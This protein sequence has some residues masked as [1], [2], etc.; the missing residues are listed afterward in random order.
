MNNEKKPRA[1]WLAAFRADSFSRATAALVG[2]TVVSQ[3]I[4]TASMLILTRLYSPDDFKIA[5]IYLSITAT[6]AAVACLRLE[7]AIPH[8]SSDL[9][10]AHLLALSLASSAVLGLISVIFIGL[11]SVLA[12]SIFD[13]LGGSKWLIPAGIWIASSFNALQY[14]STR[15]RRF[16]E[17]GRS[18]IIQ[19]CTSVAVQT[20]LGAT[21]GG[22][23]G[24]IVGHT[25][26]MGAGCLWL[27]RVIFESDRELLSQISLIGA[28]AQFRRYKRFPQFS[29]FEAFTNV[30]GIQ[31]PILAIAATVANAEAGFVFLAMRVMNAPLQI[32]GGAIG[33]VFLSSASEQLRAGCLRAYTYSTLKTL[34]KLGIIPL[35]FVGLIAPGAFSLLFGE[36]W[37]RTG[38]LVQWMTPWFILQF[39]ASPISMA[40]HVAGRVALALTIQAT[41]MALRLGAVFLSA[42]WLHGYVGE[43]YAIS[44]AVFYLLYLIVIMV[45]V[46][47]GEKSPK[48]S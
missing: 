14:W 9:D 16:T 39:L 37:R 20:T 27:L 21:A 25:V 5:S 8:P 22:P 48:L 2:S 15:S 4:V 33:E 45:V 11:I 17:V 47:R 28:R 35:S 23:L 31:G 42:E 1:S 29:T 36:E 34:A 10:A 38:E 41:G 13:G 30:V 19:S 46:G 6:F 43:S 3:G 18:R 24:L 7:I 40:L 12:G 32:V 44:G 26:F